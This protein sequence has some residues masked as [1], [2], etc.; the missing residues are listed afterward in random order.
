LDSQVA[1][2]PGDF[3]KALGACAPH[4]FFET[5]P[6]QYDIPE[7]QAHKYPTKEEYYALVP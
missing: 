2:I 7:Y 6:A 3:M 5:D 1:V 4:S